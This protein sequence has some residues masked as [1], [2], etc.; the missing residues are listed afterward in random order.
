MK[1]SVTLMILNYGATKAHK[2]GFYTEG[3]NAKEAIE[4]AKELSKKSNPHGAFVEAQSAYRMDG[5]SI[6]HSWV[7]EKYIVGRA[8]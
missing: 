7:N 4:K 8:D 1:F 2:S 6:G 3:A 5:S